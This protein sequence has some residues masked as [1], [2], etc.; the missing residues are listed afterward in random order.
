MRSRRCPEATELIVASFDPYE[1]QLWNTDA[2]GEAQFIY[3]GH[4]WK[5]V[6]VAVSRDGRRIVSSVS[7]DGNPARLAD[8]LNG[9]CRRGHLCERNVEH[10]GSVNG[11]TWIS[12][13]IPYQTTCPRRSGP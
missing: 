9:C 4:Q 8:L 5:V 2:P 1:V 7:A 10:G 13:E 6:S 11:T 12:D 3:A